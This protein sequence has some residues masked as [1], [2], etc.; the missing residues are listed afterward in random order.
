MGIL[1]RR[2]ERNAQEQR[3]IRL[4]TDAVVGVML[5]KGIWE[6]DDD[7]VVPIIRDYLGGDPNLVGGMLGRALG[8]ALNVGGYKPDSD[9]FADRILMSTLIGALVIPRGQIGLTLFRAGAQKDE[10][11]Y[12]RVFEEELGGDPGE[13]TNAI[14]DALT[15]VMVVVTHCP[16]EQAWGALIK[17]LGR[18]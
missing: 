12:A 16:V 9:D 10:L 2:T 5:H 3:R 17:Q 18:L 7:Q 8:G 14:F 15:C 6:Q 13:V 4:R 1:T 11:E